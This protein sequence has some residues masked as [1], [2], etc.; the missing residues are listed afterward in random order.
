AT[1][2]PCGLPGP[3]LYCHPS[4]YAGRPNQLFHNNGDGTFSDVSESSGVAAVSG[5]G[6]GVAF[7]DFDRDGLVDV[8]VA[9]DSVRNFLFHNKGKGKFEET[10]LLAGVAY[11]D[12]GRPLAGMGA[13]F[14]DVDND[15]RPDIVLT[16]MI[17]DT[18]PLFHN[19]GGPLAF[20]DWSVRSGL[21]L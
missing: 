6:M 5:K 21:S 9:N 2:P 19:T 20:E 10:G 18:Y 12:D 15:G 13:D 11:N 1:E 16:T 4:A 7:A 8:F 14:R 3:R 17:N